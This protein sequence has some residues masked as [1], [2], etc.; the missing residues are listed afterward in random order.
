ML[1]R[2]LSVDAHVSKYLPSAPPASSAWSAITISWHV[3]ERGDWRVVWH[4]GGLTGF[5]SQFLR[6]IDGGVTVIALAN[7]DDSDIASIAN[8]VALFYLPN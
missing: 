2:R 1:P 5:A 3:G 7:G 8:R 6:F 4:G